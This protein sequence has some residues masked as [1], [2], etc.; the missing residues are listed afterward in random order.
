MILLLSN[1]IYLTRVL[2]MKPT[3]TNKDMKPTRTDLDMKP[4]R[5]DK[6]NKKIVLAELFYIKIKTIEKELANGIF[7]N[8]LLFLT[9][10]KQQALD[11]LLEIS[12]FYGRIDLVKK[13]IK[14]GANC[15]VANGVAIQMA[16]R[17]GHLDIVK[18]LINSE[19]YTNLHEANIL[20]EIAENN[21]LEIMEFLS[22]NES[23]STINIQIEHNIAIRTAVDARHLNMI[24]LLIKLGADIN[25]FDGYL[26]MIA[27]K[28]S[29][30][31]IVK[32][33]LDNGIDRK[34]LVDA[35]SRAKMND[36]K[37]MINFLES[38]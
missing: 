28:H 21:Q 11:Y 1:L 33:L 7:D 23:T 34:Y 31:H 26:L 16:C 8:Y 14:K 5:T 17:N 29:D 9:N 15:N 35:M 30:I 18:Y 13:C 24:K 27:V 10:A 36:D 25:V 32:C 2:D 20:I 37:T 19:F 6:D 22:S 3:R 4:T 12:A 38:C